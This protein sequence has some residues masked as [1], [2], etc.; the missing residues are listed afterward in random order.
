MFVHGVQVG[1]RYVIKEAR[2]VIHALQLICDE[3]ERVKSAL[4][5]PKTPR[6]RRKG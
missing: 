5:P 3:V 1:S 2:I 6:K 4:V